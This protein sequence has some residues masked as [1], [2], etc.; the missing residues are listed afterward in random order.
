M[1][2]LPDTE[3]LAIEALRFYM[4]TDGVE[5][6]IE[7]PKGWNGKLPFCV[8]SGVGGKSPDP[9][10]IDQTLLSVS[11]FADNR[12]QAS[13]LSRKVMASLF[14][15]VRD[16]FRNSEGCFSHFKVTKV[17]TDTKDGL[18]GKHADA[19][20]YDATYTVWVRALHM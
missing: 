3:A 8:V 11:L 13:Y 18:S 1:N 16:G 7:I 19:A 14:Q 9:R 6:L 12:K 10:Y 15:A 2:I 4:P 5:F 17:P 20:M